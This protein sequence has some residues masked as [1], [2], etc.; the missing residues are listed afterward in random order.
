MV[1]MC[2]HQITDLPIPDT[3]L[4]HQIS[5]AENKK[6]KTAFITPNGLIQFRIMPFGLANVPTTFQR[7]KNQVTLENSRSFE[8]NRCS[9][10]NG[11]ASFSTQ[12]SPNK[13]STNMNGIK[14]GKFVKQ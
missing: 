5:I 14:N 11:S 2:N 7:N 1:S 8:S 3:N 13:G 10:R 6:A 9:Y 12:S 4:Y